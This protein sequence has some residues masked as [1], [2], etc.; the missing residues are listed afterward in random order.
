MK[1]R[2]NIDDSY[3]GLVWFH[4]HQ[5]PMLLAHKH[6]ELELNIVVQGTAAYLLESQH[7]NL[8]P[9]SMLWLL[10]ENE[11]ILI[12]RSPDFEMWIAVFRPSLLSKV[13]VD[14][15]TQALQW[16]RV[17]EVY[18]R[19]LSHIHLS[20]LTALC[21]DIA[22]MSNQ[23]SYVN[24]GLGF[25]LMCAWDA[26]L[27]ADQ[28]V[29]VEGLHTAVSQ[30]A[31]LLMAHHE[32]GESLDQLAYHIGLSPSRLSRLFKQQTG[33]SITE[34]RN[35]CRIQRFLQLAQMDSEPNLMDTAISSGF[36]SYAQFYR[37]FKRI[38]GRSPRAYLFEKS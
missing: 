37:T 36:G 21:Q 38:M 14:S 29:L 7:V 10:P 25:L 28:P 2:L 20:K 15:F 16:P 17:D 11:H 12:D 18:C 33:M 3:D 26:F 32:S 27:Q 5:P 19:R 6:D 31:K 9:S 35:H 23:L 30:A 34:F 24:S 1:E 4:K 8:E 22:R 13:C